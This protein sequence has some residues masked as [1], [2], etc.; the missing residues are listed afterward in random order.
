MS[1][2]H[3]TLIRAINQTAPANDTTTYF[4]GGNDLARSYDCRGQGKVKFEPLF[5]EELVHYLCS[6]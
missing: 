4:Q 2:G 5:H 1:G 3:Q 6:F